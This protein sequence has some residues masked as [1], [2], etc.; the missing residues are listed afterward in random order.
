[1]TD[2]RPKRTR[3][4]VRRPRNAFALQARKRKGG[5]MHDRRAERGGSRNWRSEWAADLDD[6]NTSQE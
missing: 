4:R 1:M 5:P 6:E 3:P 2:M